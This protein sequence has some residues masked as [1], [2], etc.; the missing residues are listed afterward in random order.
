MGFKIKPPFKRRGAKEN[1]LL[2]GW[3][4]QLFLLLGFPFLALL[5]YEAFARSSLPETFAWIG[6][7][8]ALFLVNY[9]VISALFWLFAVF[10]SD[11]FRAVLSLL[12]TAV[13]GL[14]GCVSHYKAQ[15]RLEPAL[16]IDI[17]QVQNAK[18]VLEEFPLAIRWLPI[19][20]LAL[21]TVLTTV[22]VCFLLRGRR[23]RRLTP[24]PVLGLFLLMTLSPM[25]AFQNGLSSA[26]TDLVAYARADGGV[27]TML[28]VERARQKNAYFDYVPEDARQAYEEIRGYAVPDAEETPNIIFVLSES[29]TN[30]AHLG[31]YLDFTEPITPFFEE[32]TQYG[33]SGEIRVPKQGGGTS[34]TEF[35]VLTGMPV[36]NAI[37]PYTMGVPE[38]HSVAATLRERGY[39]STA[40]HWYTAVFYNRYK[41]LR[42][43]GFDEFYTT[44]TTV[45]PFRKVGDYVSDEAHYASI[46]QTLR[47][48]EKKDF[49]FCITMQNHF[50]YNQQTD[51]APP[52]SNQLTEGSQRTAANYCRLLQESDRALRDFVQ[53]LSEFEEPTLLVFFGDHIPPLGKDFYEE[54]G[55]PV[56]TEEGYLAPFLIWS[57][58]ESI[59]PEKV[60]LRAWQLGAYA[61]AQAGITGD[62]FFMYVEML[63]AAGINDV[64]DRYR[65]LAHDALYGEQAAYEAAGFQ[66]VS[67]NWQVGGEMKLLDVDARQIGDRIYLL[68][69]LANSQQAFRLSVNGQ[70][71]DD[72]C[73]KPTEEPITIECIMANSRGVVFNRSNAITFDS[74]DSL[75]AQAKEGKSLLVPLWEEKYT[76][77]DEKSGYFVVETRRQFSAQA[78]ALLLGGE[79]LAWQYAYALRGAGLFHLQNRDILREQRPVSIAISKAD[80]KGYDM[81]SGG[82]AHYLADRDATLLLLGESVIR[83]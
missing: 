26:Q 59:A 72:W 4:I 34:E 68:P 36:Q 1:C 29:F 75:L 64:D 61:L 74:T 30:Q 9:G 3:G 48:T 13:F 70:K 2:E 51:S 24:W 49:V 45:T 53:R 57:N 83:P 44:D 39:Q 80:F 18:T 69:R 27:Y 38:L 60:T 7:Q 22:G 79:R 25:C 19:L 6:R 73:I 52:F 62:P 21:G 5:F 82:I 14:A 43:L 67:E 11:R 16:L 78:G 35:E 32:L 56:D 15:Y 28:A 71:L 41:N 10:R 8:P 40:L 20:L 37:A 65:L 47:S 31:K 58:Q 50:P 54:I 23:A 63:R 42:Q 46:L 33:I 17:F 66:I 81:T 76:I 55:M 12:L 77:S